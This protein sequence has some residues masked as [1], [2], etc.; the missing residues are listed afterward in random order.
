MDDFTFYD[1][2]P[3]V[4]LVTR[5]CKYQ[6]PLYLKTYFRQPHHKLRALAMLL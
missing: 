1:L 2:D 5:I 4:Q 3:L 6:V